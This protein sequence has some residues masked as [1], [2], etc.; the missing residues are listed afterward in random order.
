MTPCRRQVQLI[1]V[2]SSTPFDEQAALQALEQLRGQIQDARARREQKL[3]EFDDFVRSTR[4]ASHAERLAALGEPSSDGQL[5]TLHT[6]ARMAERARD[7][8]VPILIDAASR[9]AVQPAGRLEP[10]HPSYVPALQRELFGEPARAWQRIPPRIRAVAGILIL[11]VAI[12]ALSRAWPDDSPD[13]TVDGRLAATSSAPAPPSSPAASRAQD[14]VAPTGARAAAQA[15][16]PP[17]P[18][19]ALQVEL[20]TLRPVWMRVSVD[21]ERRLEREV[22][23]NQTLAFDAD[24][25]I[26]VRVGDGGAV[27]FSVNGS[28]KGALGRAGYPITRSFAPGR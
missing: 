27:R 22:N 6:A 9:T 16:T 17:P 11:I 25:A 23:A 4:A 13:S 8:V 7:A 2:E 15:R 3:A 20:T 24:R 28:D 10:V 5:P 19:G 1:G 12:G 18:A 21:G 14:P 26:V